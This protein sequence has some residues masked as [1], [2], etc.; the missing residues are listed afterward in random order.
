MS[1]QQPSILRKVYFFR[2]EHFAEL[3]SKL[4]GALERI[5]NL[6]FNDSGRYLL[7]AKTGARL[8]VF[9]DKLDFPVR[10]RFGRT[11]RDQLPEIEVNGKLEALE[12]AED[13]GLI[14]LAHVIIFDDGHV[15]AEW[16]PDGPKLQRLATYLLDKGGLLEVVKFRN[17]FER[18]IV[19]VVARLSSV[20]VLDI[21]VPPDAI[22]LA[23]EADG[24][25]AD[26]ID[27][28]EKMGATKKIGLTLTSDQGSDKLRILALKLAGI[29]KARPQ[30]RNRFI[31]LRA[32]GYDGGTSISRYVDILE[33]KLVTG[34]MFPKRD[35]R[36][37]SINSDEAYRLI[38]RS[39]LEMKPKLDGAATAGDL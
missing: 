31:T 30:E 3:K 4:T 24:N 17:L 33:D 28:T 39:Y 32:T 12:L 15:A 21:D 18:D 11:R 5:E 8:C 16:N 9:P 37:R 36:S 26:A 22:E 29:L 20:R 38:H 35:A 25:L 1:D 13:A 34:E 2:I 23:R 6:P 27:A 10:L 14:D 7:E 19:E